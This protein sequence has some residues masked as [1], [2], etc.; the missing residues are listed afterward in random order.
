VY[1]FASACD[2]GLAR[3]WDVRQAR[4]CGSM[5]SAYQI[6]AVSYA[7]DASLVYWAGV[8]DVI[9]LFDVRQL[10]TPL[11]QLA[12]HRE[13]VTSLALSSD[14]AYLLS[15]ARDNTVRLWD[16]RPF[17]TRANRC[18][19]IFVGAT[20]DQEVFFLLF[21]VFFIFVGLSLMRCLVN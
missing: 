13:A 15:N 14:G 6:L 1:R 18:L 4:S 5:E 11:V 20:H 2:D 10:D 16:A 9:R 19:K 21:F 12:G 17:S 8:D 3:L 7:R